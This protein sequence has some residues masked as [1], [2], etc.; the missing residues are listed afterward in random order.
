VILRSD[1]I[2]D[3][4]NRPVPGAQIF[5]YNIDGSSAALTSNGTTPLTQPVKSDSFGT[6]SYYANIGYY[7]EETWFGGKKLWVQSN[8]AIGSPGADLGLRTELFAPAGTA[9]IKLPDGDVQSNAVLKGRRLTYG[10]RTPV[11]TLRQARLLA[12]DIH[13]QVVGYAKTAGITG[14]Y[15]KT[16]FLVTIDGMD[17]T[18][19]SYSE[20]VGVGTYAWCLA[21]AGIAGGMI[22]FDPRG[23]FKLK[24]RDNVQHRINIGMNDITVIAPGRNVIFEHASLTGSTVIK[25]HNIIFAYCHFRTMPGPLSGDYDGSGN[26]VE[27]GLVSVF[28]QNIDKLAMVGCTYESASDGALDIAS[29]GFTTASSACLRHHPGPSVPQHR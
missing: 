9:L 8:I 13:N 29:T 27:V 1:T 12:N 21:Q 2:L 5:V 18:V 19:G 25:G 7:T 20:G 10:A 6:Y 28:P 22:V 16:L 14:G 23:S 24:I 11:T 4:Y 26:K 17:A 15:G 3:Q